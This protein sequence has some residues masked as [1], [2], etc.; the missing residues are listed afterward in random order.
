MKQN[1]CVTIDQ[2]VHEWLKA[3]PEMMSRLVNGYLKDAMIDEIKQDDDRP[4]KICKGCESTYLTKRSYC[5]KSWCGGELA[6][7]Q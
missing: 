4:H 7:M 2:S 5:P 3:K 1:M 6:V